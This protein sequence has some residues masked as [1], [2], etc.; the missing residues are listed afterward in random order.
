M[1]N[2]EIFDNGAAFMVEV[3]GLIVEGF[4]TLGAAWNHIAWMHK[5]ASQEFT[6]GKN[7]V[8]VKDWIDHMV[9][10]GFMESDCG[11]HK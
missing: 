8:P 9:A 3:N 10:I 4:N 2:I 7:K 11:M 6:V 5:V 1:M